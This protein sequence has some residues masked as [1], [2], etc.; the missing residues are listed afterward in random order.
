MNVIAGLVLAAFGNFGVIGNGTLLLPGRFCL[1]P[2]SAT[3]DKTIATCA[4]P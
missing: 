2:L 4:K 1:S 3:N